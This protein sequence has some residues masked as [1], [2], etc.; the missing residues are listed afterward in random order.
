MSTNNCV[1]CDDNEPNHRHYAVLVRQNGRLL[2]RLT[3]DGRTTRLNIYAS[4][5]SRS[6]AEYITERIN[7]S[8]NG[9]VDGVTAR[10][11]PF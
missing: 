10:V 8:V 3:P 4:V 7:S 11:I 1:W 6:R 5:M 2:G 9:R